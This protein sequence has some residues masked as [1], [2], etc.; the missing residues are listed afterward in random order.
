ME[1]A[2]GGFLGVLKPGPSLWGETSLV[3]IPE[4]VHAFHRAKGEYVVFVENNWKNLQIVYRIQAPQIPDG[5]P[6]VSR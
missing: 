6:T 2:N 4:A 1:H 3:D 5:G